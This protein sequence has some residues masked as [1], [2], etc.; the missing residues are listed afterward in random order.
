MKRTQNSNV[1]RL[2]TGFWTIVPIIFLLVSCSGST[3]G[4]A[5]NSGNTNNSGGPGKDAVWM[6]NISYYPDSLS[7]SK[8]TTITWTNK[9]M[10]D[11]TVTTGI[12]GSPNGIFDSGTLSPGQT[13]SYTFDSTGT[14]KYYCKIHLTRMT[15]VIN[16]K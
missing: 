11:H 15:G 6:Q 8:G 4:Y 2:V 3:T 1:S 9:D 13:F 10:V 7:V 5:S 14:F 12:P 16:V